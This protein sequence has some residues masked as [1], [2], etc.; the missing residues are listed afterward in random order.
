M[1]C[2]QFFTHAEGSAEALQNQM[3][4]VYLSFGVA[5][6]EV[7]VGSPISIIKHLRVREITP[8]SECFKCFAQGNNGIAVS[9]IE[10]IVKVYEEILVF[11]L[12]GYIYKIMNFEFIIM[13]LINRSVVIDE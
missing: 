8:Q 9:V 10:R 2:P 7:Y 12:R 11:H 3:L 6:P 1:L 5:A 4:A 13:H